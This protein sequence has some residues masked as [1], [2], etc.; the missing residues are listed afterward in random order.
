MFTRMFY[1]DGHGLKYFNKFD[2]RQGI[3]GGRIITWKVDWE[4]TDANNVYTKEPEGESAKNIGDEQAE[5]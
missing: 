4:G 1:L 3:T 5:K 2:D